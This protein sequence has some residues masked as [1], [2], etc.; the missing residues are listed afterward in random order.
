M[1]GYPTD[2]NVSV[3]EQVLTD[4]LGVLDDDEEEEDYR[5]K[6]YTETGQDNYFGGAKYELPIQ[7]FGLSNGMMK[8]SG[9]YDHVQIMA[10]N[11]FGIA[12]NKKVNV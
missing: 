6:S 11:A 7:K 1:R 8:Q 9:G 12:D 10:N 5:P 3:D 4:I 2:I